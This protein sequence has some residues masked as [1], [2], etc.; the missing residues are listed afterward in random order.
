MKLKNTGDREGTEVVQL[1]LQDVTASLVRPVREL[2]GYQ[3]VSLPAGAEKEV[4]LTLLKQDMGFYDNAAKYVLEDG[5]FRI[6]VGGNS[7]DT[8][9]REINVRF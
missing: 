4:Y 3:R 8:L 1:Y 9:M 5:L 2:K 7:M 6:Y